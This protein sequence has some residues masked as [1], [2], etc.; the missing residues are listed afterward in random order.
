MAEISYLLQIKHISSGMP[1]SAISQWWEAYCHY[2]SPN[3]FLAG[4]VGKLSA[5]NVNGLS[6]ISSLQ[7]VPYG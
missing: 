3:R 2:K 1:I 7:H 4:S 6:T 5:I